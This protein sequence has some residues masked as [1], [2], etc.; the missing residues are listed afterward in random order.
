MPTLEQMSVAGKKGGSAPKKPWTE[1]ELEIVRRDFRH[2]KASKIELGARLGR[3]EASVGGAIAKMGIAKRSDR[4]P[5]LPHEDEILAQLITMYAPITVANK[6]HRSLNSVVVRSKRIGVSR[7]TRTGWFTKREV[8]EILGMDHK[9]V[10]RRIDLGALKATYHFPGRRPTKLGYSCWHIDE[11]D[12][13]EYLRRYP[14]ELTSRNIDLIVIV[15][16]LVGVID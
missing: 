12:L 8:C 3:S 11:K 14:Q 1:Y 16:I 7:R 6:M 9:W 13:K 4:H 2:T 15:D 10:Q 5:W